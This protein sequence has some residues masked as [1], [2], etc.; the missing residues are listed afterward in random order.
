M[1]AKRT[2]RFPQ[3]KASAH[4]SEAPMPAACARLLSALADALEIA[5]RERLEIPRDAIDAVALWAL[6]Q[7]SRRPAR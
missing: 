1:R 2:R 3:V 4:T 5:K 7:R 6:R